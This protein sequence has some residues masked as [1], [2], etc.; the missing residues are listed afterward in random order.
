MKLTMILIKDISNKFV[1]V[2]E[3]VHNGGKGGNAGSYHELSALQDQLHR[4]LLKLGQEYLAG[5]FH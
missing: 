4:V 2:R 1:I 5:V 3:A